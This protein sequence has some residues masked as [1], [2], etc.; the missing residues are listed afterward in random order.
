MNGFDHDGLVYIAKT[1]GLYYLM[2]FSVGVV[3]YTWWPRNKKKF[4][5]AARSILE[6]DDRPCP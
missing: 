2:A 6:K 4:D 5:A 1:L 3:I